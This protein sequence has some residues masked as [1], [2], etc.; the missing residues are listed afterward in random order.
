[1]TD[2]ELRGQTADFRERLDNGASLD[3]LLPEAFATV[4]EATKRVLGKRP[5]DVQ[6]MGGA[7][8]HEGNV[9][10]MKTGEGKTIVALAPSYLNALD[11]KGV[12]VVTVND[13]L[14]QS[15]AEQ[16]GRVHHFLG[17]KTGVILA[18]MAPD[19]RRRAYAC[20]ITYGT[21]NEFGFDYLRDNMALTLDDCVQNGHHFAIAD[22]VDSILIDEARTPLIISGPATE[23][24]Q[25]YPEFARLAV[26]LE[27]DTDYEVDEKKRTVSVLAHGI[28]VT[29]SDLGIDNLY[30]SAN[31]PLI[32][33]LNNAIK[34]KEL[35]KRDKDYVVIDG[36]VLIVDEHT[37]RVLAGRRYN[38]GL[39]QA[40]EAKEK[41]EIK[42]EYQT[43][44]TITLQ[45][46]FRMY[47]KL[48]G[49]TGTAKTEEDEFQKVYGLGVLEIPTNKPMIRKDQS[50]LIYRSEDAK[51]TAIV[52]D[53]V[54]RHDNGQPVLIGTASVVKSE[55]LSRRLRAAG[56]PTRCSMPSSMPVRLRWWRR[57]DARA[58]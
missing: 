55:E 4:R 29:E 20:D 2:E 5:F 36:E 18:P 21:N 45:N 43:L 8:L 34:A 24:K 19:E 31:T 27:R 7:A 56:I 54:E 23:N 28:E 11:G 16:M 58:P 32:G 30:E 41:V 3:D 10:E 42:D 37:G 47:D 50:D 44:A 35:F 6:I 25:W 52:D 17:L 40:L 26:R 9:A 53:V 38:E 39:H 1:M 57:P 33:Y 46:Y 49:M 48:S 12:H 14:A 13:Y 51:F 22:E 15:Q